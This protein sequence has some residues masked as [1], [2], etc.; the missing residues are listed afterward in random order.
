VGIAIAPDQAKIAKAK[1]FAGNRVQSR[2]AL[3]VKASAGRSRRDRIYEDGALRV[4]FPNGDDLEAVVINTAGGIAG[5]DKFTFE[6]DVGEGAALTVTTAAAEKTY[7]S[8]GEP[9]TVDV[10]L[11]VGAGGSLYW[12]PQETIL[13]N[14][15]QLRRGIEADVAEDAKLLMI[16]SVVFGRTA[17]DEAVTQGSLFDRWRLRRSGKLVFADTL[18]LDG[19]IAEKLGQPAIAAG[20][21]AIA[22]AL[23]TPVDEAQVAALREQAYTGDVG[24]SAWNG[25]ALMR[26]VARDGEIL[27]HD[28]KLLLAA[29]GGTLPRLWLN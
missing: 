24:V 29:I 6:V 8:L 16:E 1:A 28:I 3:S 20:G 17:M 2:V 27:R 22:T 19:A 10:K 18:R 13:F 12:L 14:A 4:R 26:L 11:N 15:A 25:F 5:G 23:L 9:A 21:C 7:R